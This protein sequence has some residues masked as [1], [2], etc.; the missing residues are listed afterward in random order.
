MAK[1]THLEQ[2][3][4][5]DKILHELSTPV[6]GI[7]NLS[8]VLHSEWK[9]I[10]ELT[11]HDC[12]KNIWDSAQTLA[13]LVNELRTMHDFKSS[14]IRI[15]IAEIDIINLVKNS[16]SQVNYRLDEKG[17]QSEV[18]SEM[19]V[20][21]ARVDKIWVKQLL[22]NLLNNAI[23]HT[24]AGMISVHISIVENDKSKNLH[25]AVKDQGVGIK[26]DELALIFE[27]LQQGSNSSRKIK[28]SGSGIGL[29]ICKEIT[30]K[31]YGRIWASNNEDKGATIEFSIPLS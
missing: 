29:A 24:D 1:I 25:I 11:R 5:F 22:V 8:D 18:I 6:H 20:C 4:Y 31:H 9:N 26:E 23:N 28:S 10:D 12:I 2:I 13:D 27:P 7:L 30:E 16:L 14:Q 19:N 15:D 21:M 3:S 17:L